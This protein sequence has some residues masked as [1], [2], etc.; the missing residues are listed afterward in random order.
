MDL[1]TSNPLEEM[2]ERRKAKIRF[3]LPILVQELRLARMDMR[4]FTAQGD[5]DK[6]SR[7]AGQARELQI[8]LFEFAP[9]A[10]E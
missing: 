2:E 1:F 3:G 5:F 10:V 6:A 9:K 7:A 4:E 8:I